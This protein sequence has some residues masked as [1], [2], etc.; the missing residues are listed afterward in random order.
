MPGTLRR[1]R[2]SRALG[3]TIMICDPVGERSGDGRGGPAVSRVLERQGNT[4]GTTCLPGMLVLMLMASQPGPG[5]PGA[6]PRTLKGHSGSVMA[7]AFAPD[8]KILA[9]G[10]RDGTVRLWDVKTGDLRRTLG[11]HTGDVYAVAFAPDGRLL[12]TGGGDRTVRLW[13][14]RTARVIRMLEGHGDIIRSVAFAPDQRTLAS[15]GVDGTIRL[16]D[17]P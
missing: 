4:M 6:R 14:V 11:V 3:A 9:S 7:V 5:T 12:A 10:S 16:W 1:K 15:A 17:V 8:G 2:W 13:D